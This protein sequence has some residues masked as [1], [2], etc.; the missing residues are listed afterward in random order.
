MENFNI[1]ITARLKDNPVTRFLDEL[2]TTIKFISLR[3]GEFVLA[4]RIGVKY[5]TR[6]AFIQGVK[7]RTVYRDIIELKREYSEPILVVEG[8]RGLEVAQDVT[9]LQSAQIYISALNRIPI[10]TT[11][12]EAETA[13]L[14]FMLT[15]QFGSNMDQ[16]ANTFSTG[17]AVE[18]AAETK[19]E[20]VDPV[21]RIVQMLP[22]V[23]RAL[24]ES[25]LNHFGSL[26]GLFAAEL[27]DL[28][29]VEG[30][31]PKRA[32]RIHDF[33]HQPSMAVKLS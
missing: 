16:T 32:K 27:K 8:D 10:L 12:D 3:R 4:G 20:D 9:T 14:L 30:L 7:D 11:R 21:H 28:K 33:L 1:V 23:D 29:K 19:V 18:P 5:V 24:A 2:G 22:N 25:L 26:A 6:Q 15:A 13:Q 31:G 17:E